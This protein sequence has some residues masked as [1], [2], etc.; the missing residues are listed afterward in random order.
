MFF[1]IQLEHS[2]GRNQDPVSA[3]WI[4]K[5]KEGLEEKELGLQRQSLNKPVQAWPSPSP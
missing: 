5:D 4:I 1:G 2:F 3:L